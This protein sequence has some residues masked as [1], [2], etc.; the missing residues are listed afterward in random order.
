MSAQ[1]AVERHQRRDGSGV[2]LYCC[3]MTLAA[4]SEGP[5]GLLVAVG[6]GVIIGGKCTER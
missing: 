3:A 6:S 1:L 2:R 5:K 4:A